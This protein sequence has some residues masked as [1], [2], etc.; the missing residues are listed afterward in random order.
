MLEIIINRV[1]SNSIPQLKS[2]HDL[3]LR[4]TALLLEKP[5]I[6]AALNTGGIYNEREKI[7]SG[8]YSQLWAK[9]FIDLEQQKGNGML[10]PTSRIDNLLDAITIANTVGAHVSK[11]YKGAIPSAFADYIKVKGRAYL[12]EY[13]MH[14]IQQA[15]NA[16]MLPSNDFRKEFV[17][18]EAQDIMTKL[19]RF[20]YLLDNRSFDAVYHALQSRLD[21]AVQQQAVE[22]QQ[23]AYTRSSLVDPIIARETYGLFSPP[24]EAYHREA[25]IAPTVQLNAVQG[26]DATELDIDEDDDDI[27]SDALVTWDD[28]EHLVNYAQQLRPAT[29]QTAS[30]W[31]LQPFHDTDEIIKDLH[32]DDS[33]VYRLIPLN[34]IP[35]Q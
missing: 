26:G 6:S 10:N 33:G 30:N 5:D 35:K 7:R 31:H 22:S 13:A 28:T 29:D 15:E 34:Q 17:V 25:T 21:A 14:Y 19:H 18:K 27:S 11:Y 23:E 8:I 9:G 1:P 2:E 32:V 3:L 24:S 16:S 20:M 12:E 4:A